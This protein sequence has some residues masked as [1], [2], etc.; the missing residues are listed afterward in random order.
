MFGSFLLDTDLD[1]RY[2]LRSKGWEVVVS[3]TP[4]HEAAI[5]FFR[6][7]CSASVI[8]RSDR[9]LPGRRVTE[10][11]FHIVCVT[12]AVDKLSFS[13][14]S[15]TFHDLKG[16]LGLGTGRVIHRF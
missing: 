16:R 2:Y 7:C 1:S 8:L 11:L 10:L 9:T 15:P 13:T 6:N 5:G 3:S 12:K 14:L 4:H